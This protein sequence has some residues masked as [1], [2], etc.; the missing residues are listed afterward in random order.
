MSLWRGQPFGGCDELNDVGIE[1]RRLEELHATAIDE[2]TEARLS[3][4]HHGALCAELSAL[5]AELPFA[6]TAGRSADA[7]ALPIRSSGRRSTRLSRTSSPA[8]RRARPDAGTELRELERDVLLQD[9]RLAWKP[10]IPT[11]PPLAAP[12]SSVMV[13]EL[14]FVGR[15]REL[16]LLLGLA[17]SGGS[18]PARPRVAIVEGEAGIGESRLIAELACQCRAHGISF[19]GG[20]ADGLPYE[21]FKVVL[22]SIVDTAGGALLSRL[23]ELGAYLAWLLPELGDRPPLELADLGLARSRMFESV[24]RLL[25]LAGE[26]APLVV[27]I[28]DAQWMDDA[29]LALLRGLLKRDWERQVVVVLATPAPSERRRART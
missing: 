6:R 17:S 16:A 4:G 2:L 12:A 27:A 26:P 14:P 3:L 20:W 25:A 5:V 13:T 29:S 22:R 9:E 19:A 10:H 7:G 28:D 1:A 11:T 24:A 21:P 18:L 23:G 8:R 15:N